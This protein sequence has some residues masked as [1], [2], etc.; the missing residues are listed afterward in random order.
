[1]GARKLIG[2]GFL[3][4]GMGLGGGGPIP[5]RLPRRARECGEQL[6]QEQ[7]TQE[8]GVKGWAWCTHWGQERSGDLLTGTEGRV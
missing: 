5:S 1:M 3:D 2:E 6:G 4:G 8:R 7:C